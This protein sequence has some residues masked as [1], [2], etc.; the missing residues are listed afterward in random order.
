MGLGKTGVPG[1]NRFPGDKG[2]PGEDGEVE[3]AAQLLCSGEV[4]LWSSVGEEGVL[5]SSPPFSVPFPGATQGL[6][7]VGTV[8]TTGWVGEGA[9]EGRQRYWLLLGERRPTVTVGKSLVLD[10]GFRLG[11]L[12]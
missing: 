1:E 8:H 9:W 3:K 12:S 5:N 11:F 10:E 7:R 4:L 6:G 2:V